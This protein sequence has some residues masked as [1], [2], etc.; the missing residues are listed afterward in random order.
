ML[1]AELVKLPF[2]LSDG[3]RSWGGARSLRARLILLVIVTMSPLLVLGLVVQ[4]TQYIG[5]KE[6]ASERTL[7]LAQSVALQVGR[8][9]EADVRALQV[10]AKTGRLRRGAFEE[11]RYLAESAVSDHLEGA[12]IMV[13]DEN[14]QQLMNTALPRGT[15]LPRRQTLDNT[16][17]ASASGEPRVSDVYFGNI[18]RR[19]AVAIE[20][21]V[22]D[23]QGHVFYTLTR[24][25]RPDTFV[26]IIRRQETRKGVVIALFDR[27]G[28]IIARW[29]D[30]NRF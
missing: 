21:P 25:P 5:D 13:V 23:E 8:E 16:Q 9:L 22:K 19:P 1:A 10:L 14:G 11:F 18:L 30:S 29:P 20:V 24:D 28:T 7:E 2:H 26:D 4:Y 3:L 17:A 12:N 27:E 6:V 15:P